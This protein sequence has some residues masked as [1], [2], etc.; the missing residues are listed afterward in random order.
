[1]IA[2]KKLILIVDML[3]GFTEIGLLS[4]P[5]IKISS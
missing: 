4:S 2:N 5:Y 1:M 3:K